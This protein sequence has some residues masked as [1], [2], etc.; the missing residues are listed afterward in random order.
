M[1]APQPRTDRVRFR[2]ATNDNETIVADELDDLDVEGHRLATNDNET[3]VEGATPTD[4]SRADGDAKPAAP[5]GA[6]R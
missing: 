2:L 3:V 6:R 4:D 5:Q 1:T